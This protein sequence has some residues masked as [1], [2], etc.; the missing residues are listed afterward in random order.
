MADDIG[1]ATIVAALDR[2]AAASGDAFGY[3]S[4]SPLLRR[5]AASGERLSDWRSGA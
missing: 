4:V 5:L 1:L 3:W 2:R